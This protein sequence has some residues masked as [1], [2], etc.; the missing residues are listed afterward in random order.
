MVIW[1]ELFW[2]L[3]SATVANGAKRLIVRDR[4]F[5]I[6]VRAIAFLMLVVPIGMIVPTT[7]H[8]VAKVA[9]VTLIVAVIAA[10]ISVA[11]AVVVATPWLII[12][13]AV[14]IVAVVVAA[15]I[16]AAIV[17]AA[18]VV[19]ATAVVVCARAT[20]MRGPFECP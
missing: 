14:I 10:S 1:L 9:A 19:A 3:V 11:I 13:M 2:I 6:L 8:I 17:V 18:V 15:V 7:V 20:L 5:R 16:V 4:F 12:A